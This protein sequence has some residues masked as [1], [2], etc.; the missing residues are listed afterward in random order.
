VQLA[1]LAEQHARA[2]AT[3]AVDVNSSWRVYATHGMPCVILCCHALQNAW[4]TGAWSLQK[5]QHMST[6]DM[7]ADGKANAGTAK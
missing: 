4:T 2:G 3:R 5:Y 7:Q 6:T 1:C